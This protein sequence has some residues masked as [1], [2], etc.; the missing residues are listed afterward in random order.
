MNAWGLQPLHRLAH[1]ILQINGPFTG[2]PLP[3]V[4]AKDEPTVDEPLPIGGEVVDTIDLG[5]LVFP[6]RSDLLWPTLQF[7]Q[8][9]ER[10][11]QEIE[12]H[13]ADLFSLGPELLEAKQ[14]SGMPVWR[15]LV[16]FVLVDLGHHRYGAI[17][18]RGTL[19]RPGGGTMGL[20]RVTEQGS[21]MTQRAL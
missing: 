10:D 14:Q 19:P 3:S 21:K 4:G 17:E 6:Q 18:R 12:N 8:A 2:P 9:Q 20:Y 7:I 1:G 15:N 5:A 13:L 11:S 16:S